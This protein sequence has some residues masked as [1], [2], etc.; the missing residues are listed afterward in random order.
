MKELL[1]LI[2]SY[3]KKSFEVLGDLK[4]LDIPSNALLYSAD[5]KSMY[6]NI[7]T[8]V[9]I[10]SFRDFFAS[11]KTLI[12]VNIPV[13]LFLRILE[14]VMS[15]NIFSFGNTT[16]LQ[17]SGTAMGTPAACSYATITYGQYKNTMILTEFDA[18]LLYY[19]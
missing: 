5:A 19:Q 7:D 13:N 1:P 14:L 9:G 18:Q 2:K 8:T 6:T 15:N 4:T 12:P 11:H 17:L 16:L 3:T 10:Q